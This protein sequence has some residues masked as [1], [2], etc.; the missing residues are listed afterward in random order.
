MKRSIVLISISAVVFLSL[1]P[2]FATK[3]G[4]IPLSSAEAGKL[5]AIQS[6]MQS[7]NINTKAVADVNTSSPTSSAKSSKPESISQKQQTDSSAD[8][9]IWVKCKNPDC[10]AE[11]QM[12]KREYFRYLQKN[13]DPAKF[14][15]TPALP[16]NECGQES[17][18]RAVK[19][20]KCGKV[21]FYGAAGRGDF[22]DR[23]SEC[24][25]SKT[26]DLRRLRRLRR[27]ASSSAASFSSNEVDA[28]DPAEV[29]R[30][31]K[32]LNVKGQSGIRQWTRDATENKINL[33]K[34]VDEQVTAE[35]NFIRVL[36]VT[37]GA[38][39][40]TEAID[41]VLASRKERSQ[42]TIKQMEEQSKKAR[43]SEQTKRQRGQTR[44]TRS[45]ERGRERD[46]TRRRSM[47]DR[48]QKIVPRR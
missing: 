1:L 17:I 12:G 27:R 39:K 42:K 29:E 32:R 41:A 38:V 46:T 5:A 11:Y 2:A 23:C 6:L 4:D 28:N 13:M 34:A 44:G 7:K 19:C 36:A 25:Y 33:A 9:M 31:L 15:Q 20:A 43:A 48:I 40:T 18:Y 22:A 24:G 37:E 16:C 26:E 45:R 30:T 35:L 10:G 14:M 47:E 21:F 8:E 3:A